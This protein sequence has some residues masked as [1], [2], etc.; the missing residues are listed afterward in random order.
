MW[1]SEEICLSLNEEVIKNQFSIVIDEIEVSD[2]E[3]LEVIA[4]I[5][6]KRIVKNELMM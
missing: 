2:D 6:A 3:L 1:C 4:Y 5:K